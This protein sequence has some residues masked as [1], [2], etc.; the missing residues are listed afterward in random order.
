MP[1][2]DLETADGPSNV[3]LTLYTGRGVVL[4]TSGRGLAAE[5]AAPWTDRV[6][7]V[8]ARPAEGLAEGIVLVR[9]DGYAAFVDPDG[10]DGP[11]LR[12]ALAHWFGQG[13]PQPAVSS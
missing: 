9:P 5:A 13:R 12:E 1:P 3:A 7:V 10:T 11:G 6:D 8:V 2:V 4:D